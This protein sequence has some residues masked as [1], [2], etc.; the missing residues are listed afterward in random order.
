[1]QE[2]NKEAL[3]ELARLLD[4]RRPVHMSVI[5]DEM[6]EVRFDNGQHH[7]FHFGR[8]TCRVIGNAISD[9]IL[10]PA[11]FARRHE[12]LGVTSP[13]LTLGAKVIAS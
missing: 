2:L 7:I 9:L 1:M 4:G 12:K 13:L 6:F 11:G 3:E 5:T 10:D 8:V